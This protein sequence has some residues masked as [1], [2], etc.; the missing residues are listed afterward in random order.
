MNLDEYKELKGKVVRLLSGVEDC[1]TGF[2]PGMLAAV[3]QV[4]LK[5]EDTMLVTLDFSK[6]EAHNKELM[7]PNYYNDEHLPRLKWC[8]TKFYPENKRDDLFLALGDPPK[9]S[10]NYFHVV[11]TAADRVVLIPQE[12]VSE[13]LELADSVSPANEMVMDN[14]AVQ[15]ANAVRLLLK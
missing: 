15:L 13:L 8:E 6:F 3:C 1:E 4:D 9:G 5:D 7:S 11:G 10:P 14:N 12:K 2:E